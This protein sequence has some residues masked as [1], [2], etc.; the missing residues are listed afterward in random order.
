MKTKLTSAM[1]FLPF[2]LTHCASNEIGQSRDVNQEAIYQQYHVECDMAAGTAYIMAQFRFAGENGTTL[3][4]SNPS[5]LEYNGMQ[6]LVDSNGISGAF[7]RKNLSLQE[8]WGTQQL[9]YTD[10]NKTSYKN[11]FWIDSFYLYPVNEPISRLVPAH[12]YFKAP[13]LNPDDYIEVSSIGTDSSFTIMYNAD[14]A[15]NFISIPVE[16]LQRQKQTEL[17]LTATLYRRLPLQQQSREGG[18][19]TIVQSVLPVLILLKKDIL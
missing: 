2:L 8:V 14:N 3:V 19:I 4:L 15:E 9:E 18:A 16:E 11:N 1:F 17:N 13:K 7:Y 10:F 6:L 5:K 12:L